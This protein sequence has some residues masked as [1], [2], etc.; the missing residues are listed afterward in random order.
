MKKPPLSEGLLL[1]RGLLTW[2]QHRS[3]GGDHPHQL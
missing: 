3:T 2:R 1:S